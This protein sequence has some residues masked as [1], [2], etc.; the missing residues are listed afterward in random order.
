M[1]AICEMDELLA[2][3]FGTDPEKARLALDTFEQLRMVSI[4][5]DRRI[6]LI[7]PVAGNSRPMVLTLNDLANN[8]AS[9]K[10]GRNG[11]S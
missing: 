4:S 3:E 7:H 2:R 5:P 6:V 9:E 8:L 1:G 10:G 11:G